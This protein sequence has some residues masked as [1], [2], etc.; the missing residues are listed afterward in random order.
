M[1][2][3]I[4]QGMNLHRDG[5]GHGF[6]PFEAEMRRRV[7][8]V[9]V[10]LDLRAAEDR[11]TAAVLNIASATTKP[12]T[13]IDDDD[14]SP[15]SSGPL[16]A[17]ES[18]QAENIITILLA[19]LAPFG[20]ISHA[21]V[22]AHRRGE[23][24]NEDHLHTEEDLIQ[25][26]RSLESEFIHN[27]DPGNLASRYA[28]EVTRLCILKLW[29]IVQ[30]PFSQ[31]PTV[32]PMRVSRETML[33]TAVSVMELSLRMSEPPWVDR[34]SWWTETY[35]QWHP[36]AVALAELCVQTEGE[37]VA[38][39]WTVVDTVFPLWRDLVADASSGPL[40]RPVKKLY[41]KAREARAKSGMKG[42]QLAEN[43]GTMSAR[44]PPPPQQKAPAHTRAQMIPT[45]T[46]TTTSSPSIPS[47]AQQ[48]QQQQQPPPNHQT[49]TQHVIHDVPGYSTFDTM[50][51]DPSCLFSYPPE[52]TDMNM[53][54][55][56]GPVMNFDMAPWNE[57]L[58]DTQMDYS[59][60]S[61]RSDST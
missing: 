59:P 12:P 14:F 47:A 50:G 58:I 8:C 49:P 22:E 40:W 25:L 7:W 24:S 4:A 21:Y 28:S 31:K 32:A 38:R 26:V 29:L 27:A 33:R 51:M 60:G 23:D 34:F 56:M 16:R 9:V 44:P 30:Y 19:R 43:L 13:P 6:S 36:L 37:L 54:P 18:G 17:K 3:R 55:G 15:E 48:Q 61:G 20:F 1:V 53:S 45:T 46:A 57:F 10:N 39:A 41:K 5:D 35:V 11:G 42:L 52:L 2:V